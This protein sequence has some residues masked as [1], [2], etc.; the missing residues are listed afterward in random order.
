MHRIRRTSSEG[1]G[2]HRPDVHLGGLTYG[3]RDLASVGFAM[4]LK[5]QAPKKLRAHAGALKT[6]WPCGLS[7]FSCGYIAFLVSDVP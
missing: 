3:L 4:L 7:S 5:L 6:S 1:W 2:Y